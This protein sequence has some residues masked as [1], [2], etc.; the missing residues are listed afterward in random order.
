M[1]GFALAGYEVLENHIQRE[2]FKKIKEWGFDTVLITF[3]WSFFEEEGSPYQYNEENLRIFR[4]KIDIAIDEGLIVIL[5]G[6]VCLDPVEMP[7][8]AGWS[9]HDYVIQNDEGLNRYIALWKML[10]DRFPDCEYCPW[11]FPYH[12]QDCS[13]EK[14]T[15]YHEYIF[16]KLLAGIRE[17]TNKRI[18]YSPIWQGN[19]DEGSTWYEQ[20]EPLKDS[21]ILYGVG[22]MIPWYVTDQGNWNYDYDRLDR[23]FKGIK[24][25]R[26]MGLPM[27]SIEFSPLYWTHQQRISSSRVDCLK[28]SLK[29]L[30][31][32]DV[33]FLYWRMSL[34]QDEGDNIIEDIPTFKPIPEIFK[35][36]KPVPQKEIAW[37]GII[38]LIMAI[39]LIFYILKNGM[40]TG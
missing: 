8:W 15:R 2:H 13:T 11:H 32:Y 1:N 27:V 34:Y 33:G 14:K 26:N 23:A 25:F 29:R 6:R 39:I 12:R 40:D 9:T 31:K 37:M 7:D 3:W 28:E 18:I 20:N 19:A 10:I 16:P 4:S 5:S 24:R 30:K 35:I 21:N 38:L 22:H 36:I 17:K